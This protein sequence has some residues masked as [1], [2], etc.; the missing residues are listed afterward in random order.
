MISIKYN[1][2]KSYYAKSAMREKKWWKR[3]SFYKT[4]GLS[5]I[6]IL[7]RWD[8]ECF[9]TFKILHWNLLIVNGDNKSKQIYKKRWTEHFLPWLG[10]SKN[11]EINSTREIV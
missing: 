10:F 2:I 8:P 6:S 7:I 5:E 1:T 3:M 11:K 9:E 4:Q